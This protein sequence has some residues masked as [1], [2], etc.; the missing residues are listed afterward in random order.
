MSI[1][2]EKCSGAIRVSKK[3]KRKGNLIAT[4][5]ILANNLKEVIDFRRTEILFVSTE[6]ATAHVGVPR[7]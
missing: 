2:L 6:A 3:K 4:G 1:F 5:P 7:R